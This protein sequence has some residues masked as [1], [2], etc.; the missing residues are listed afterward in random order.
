[1]EPAPTGLGHVDD[2]PADGR[3]VSVHTVDTA[4]SSTNGAPSAGASVTY[5]AT[6]VGGLGV[7]STDAD[8]TGGAA[9]QHGHP[10]GLAYKSTAVVSGMVVLPNGHM[11]TVTDV[12]V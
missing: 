2:H 3:S 9:L 6:D 1:V 12:S 5:V 11:A 8:A 7:L 10:A 4:P